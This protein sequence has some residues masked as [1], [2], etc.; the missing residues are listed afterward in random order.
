MAL[1]I[2]GQEI[3]TLNL[4]GNLIETLTIDGV[5][6]ARKPTI[7]TQPV[8][9]TITD[10]ETI[11]LSVVAD[12][13]DSTMTYQWYKSDGT[14]ISGATGTSYTFTPSVTGSFEFYC[15]VTGFGG[16]TDSNTVIVTV[17]ASVSILTP[18]EYLELDNLSGD[19]VHRG[20]DR[21]TYGS[22]TNDSTAVEGAEGDSLLSLARFNAADASEFDLTKKD[23][24]NFTLTAERGDYTRAT[25]EL[26]DIT[27]ELILDG[28]PLDVVLN[29][30]YYFSRH[31]A[32]DPE[33]AKIFDKLWNGVGIEMNIK[34]TMS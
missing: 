25:V 2:D 33:A 26:D 6:V 10:E 34:I 5:T 12:G 8:G 20:Y 17:N 19:I 15:R 30:A 4:D 29:Y 23:Y 27:A 11:A 22:L 13:L 9:G 32:D 14:A 1:F 16:Y 21:E 3:L 7:T 28:K 18:A 31:T 24:L